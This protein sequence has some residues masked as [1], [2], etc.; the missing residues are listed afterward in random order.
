MKQTTDEAYY[1][2]YM[3]KRFSK[4]SAEWFSLACNY[5]YRKNQ[6]FT[7]LAEQYLNKQ[8]SIT[9]SYLIKDR[10]FHTTE[11]NGIQYQNP[12]GHEIGFLC[13]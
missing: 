10:D 11:N 7:H 3:L 5:E 9:S 13:C 1:S 4:F 2:M 6:I 8:L 12:R